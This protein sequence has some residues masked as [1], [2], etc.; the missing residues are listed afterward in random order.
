M[1]L[2]MIYHINKIMT[3]DK[4]TVGTARW[5]SPKTGKTGISVPGKFSLKKDIALLVPF[6]D[7]KEVA[8]EVDEEKGTVCIRK[9]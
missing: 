3:S 6:E 2:Y 4:I 1:V 5:Y 9:L 7:G 8:V